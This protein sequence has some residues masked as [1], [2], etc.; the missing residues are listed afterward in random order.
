M[1]NRHR[2]SK[3]YKLAKDSRK[4]IKAIV[5]AIV[6]VSFGVSFSAIFSAIDLAT[7]N[8]YQSVAINEFQAGLGG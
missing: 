4:N 8:S 7:P 2:R 6:S 3:H 1:E 5:S